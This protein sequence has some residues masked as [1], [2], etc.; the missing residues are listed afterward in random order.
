[1]AFRAQWRLPLTNQRQDHYG[2]FEVDARRLFASGYSLF[3]SYTR[4]SARTNAALDYVPTISLLGPQQS[5]PLAM[6]HTESHYLM[7]LASDAV[8][9]SSQTLDF[10]YTVDWHTGFPY[11]AVNANR[12]VVGAAGGQR[13]PEYIDFSP[14]L[15]WKF[16]FRGA[17]FGLRGVLENASG[18]ANPVMVNNVVDSP[19]FGAFSQLEGRVAYSSHSPYW[20]EIDAMPNWHAH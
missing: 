10:V 9:D 4:S 1:M 16:H 19:Q 20:R 5:G 2:S 15:E 14:G 6:G 18:R 3:V 8:T 13:F 17:Y 11:M 7:G 12:Q